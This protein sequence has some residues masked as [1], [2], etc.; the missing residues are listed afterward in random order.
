MIGDGVVSGSDPVFFRGRIRILLTW[1]G[2]AETLFTGLQIGHHTEE[3]KGKI[4]NKLYL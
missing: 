3:K 2:S 4:E 1:T